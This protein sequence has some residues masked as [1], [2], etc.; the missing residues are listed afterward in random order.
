MACA[1]WLHLLC[2]VP[3]QMHWELEP[4][5]HNQAVVLEGAGL[6][7]LHEQPLAGEAPCAGSKRMTVFRLWWMRC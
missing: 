3:V 2:M 1:D 6:Q 4:E 7:L 5:L